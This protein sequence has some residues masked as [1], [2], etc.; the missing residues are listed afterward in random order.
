MV[1]IPTDLPEDE[2]R[3]MFDSVNGLF[4]PG[5]AQ[6]REFII[7]YLEYSYDSGAIYLFNSL[8]SSL[9]SYV[10]WVGLVS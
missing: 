4:F 6:V 3:E 5:G 10:I 9:V 8:I 1:P 2:L 7:R